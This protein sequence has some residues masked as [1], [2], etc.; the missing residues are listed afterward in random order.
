MK[1][2]RTRQQTRPGAPVQ[3]D[4]LPAMLALLGQLQLASMEEL[5][6][7]LAVAMDLLTS[8]TLD[9]E[10]A[11]EALH[12]FVHEQ[13][14]RRDGGD[15]PADIVNQLAIPAFAFGAAAAYVALTNGRT[16]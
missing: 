13:R 6:Q 1:R 2:T 7:A 9:S 10:Q 12:R 14:H 3:H 16:R 4:R 15:E 8:T 11:S 5:E